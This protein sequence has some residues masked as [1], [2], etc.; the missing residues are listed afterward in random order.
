MLVIRGRNHDIP[1]GDVSLL[2]ALQINRAGL[3]F[4]AVE[5]AAGDARNLLVVDDGLAVQDHG[6]APADES[7]VERLPHIRRTRLFRRGSEEPVHA[8]GV[9]AGRLA[10]RLG[11]DLHF[12]ASAQ[13]DAAVG[14]LAAIELHVQLEILELRVVDEFGAVARGNQGSIFARSI[15]AGRVCSSSSR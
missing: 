15:P 6:D 3:A 8:A 7:D 5:R 4:V 11:F 12:V 10:L 2:A 9:V 14:I 1:I 13:I